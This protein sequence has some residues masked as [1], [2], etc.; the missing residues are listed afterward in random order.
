MEGFDYTSIN[1]LNNISA[2]NMTPK[3]TGQMVR[4]N[5]KKRNHISPRDDKYRW[6]KL[7][8]LDI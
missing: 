1:V 4:G 6:N 7:K 2:A 3:I 5:Y 8:M